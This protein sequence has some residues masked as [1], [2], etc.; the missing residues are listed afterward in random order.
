M[1][2]EQQKS[3][4]SLTNCSPW[5]L[6]SR[7]R[8]ISS[9]SALFLPCFF[10]SSFLAKLIVAAAFLL[11]LLFFLL[12]KNS[13]DSFTCKIPFMLPE[14]C[15]Q[16]SRLIIFSSDVMS[17]HSCHSST[18]S[19]KIQL[20]KSSLQKKEHQQVSIKEYC[21]YWGL[22]YEDTLKFLKVL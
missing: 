7:C 10:L 18:A 22:E 4:K 5:R 8:N 11:F 12:H 6:Y 1:Y 2:I 3:S 15:K 20:V 17:I 13:A 21:D 19:R 9:V 16:P 14:N